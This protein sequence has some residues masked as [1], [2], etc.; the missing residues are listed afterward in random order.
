MKAVLYDMAHEAYHSLFPY[1]SE[2]DATDQANQ[3]L[4][5]GYSSP[6]YGA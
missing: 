5:T 4:G 1:F 6:D 2:S 3:C